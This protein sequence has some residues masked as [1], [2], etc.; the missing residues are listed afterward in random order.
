MSP[1]RG[2]SPKAGAGAGGLMMSPGASPRAGAAN[3]PWI[4]TLNLKKVPEANSSEKALTAHLSK[5]LSDGQLKSLMK[6]PNNTLF[7]FNAKKKEARL[8]FRDEADAKAAKRFVVKSLHKNCSAKLSQR[9]KAGQRPNIPAIPT[10]SL[11]RSPTP[12]AN[13]R[14]CMRLD[15]VAKG[16]SRPTATY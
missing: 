13:A 7:K 5:F 1:K 2:G 11:P 15:E 10:L 9:G 8:R 3:E 12:C 16:P 14:D 4:L 6:G